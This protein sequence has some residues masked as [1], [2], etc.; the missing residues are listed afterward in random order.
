MNNSNEHFF[1]MEQIEVSPSLHEKLL[2]A[3]QQAKR[4]KRRTTT[5]II[6]TFVC[7]MLNLAFFSAQ[8]E[9]LAEEQLLETQYANFGSNLSI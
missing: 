5:F 8:Q 6:A 1:P 7:V 2:Q 9:K 4:L 3:P